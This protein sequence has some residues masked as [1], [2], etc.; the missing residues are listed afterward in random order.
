MKTLLLVNLTQGI[1]SL[2]TDDSFRET[3][4]SAGRDVLHQT[5]ALNPGDRFFFDVDLGRY[6]VRAEQFMVRRLARPLPDV[7]AAD[8]VAG[9]LALA[10]FC[11]GLVGLAS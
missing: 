11:Y 4:R 5:A 2:E 8:V 3:F 7:T 6:D 9:V 10:I 1:S